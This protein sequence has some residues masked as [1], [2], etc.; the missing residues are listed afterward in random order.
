M[1]F[2]IYVVSVNHRVVNNLFNI[3]N[4]TFSYEHFYTF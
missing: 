1:D 2:D 4:V 3:E